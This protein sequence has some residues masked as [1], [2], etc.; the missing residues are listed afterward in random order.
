MRH[1]YPQEVAIYEYAILSAP[2]ILIIPY[3][4][5]KE[6][7]VLVALPI[8]MGILMVFL[9][10]RAIPLLNDNTMRIFAREIQQ[11]LRED[12][13]VGVG[14]VNISQQR[15]GIYLNRQIDEVNVKWKSPEAIPIHRD[16]LVKYI[17]SGENIYLV[18]SK[19][20]Y[21]QLIP[22]ELKT[23]LILIDKRDTWKTRLKRSFDRDIMIE[24][25]HGEKDI[26][27]DVLRHEVY[28]LTNKRL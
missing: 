21:I 2:L 3:T 1:L 4:K 12:D 19:E 20:D 24:I 9:A 22:D 11:N 13:K 27:T 10:G 18:I 8:S 26:L 6:R 15:L 7:D 25:L 16:K 17:T 23:K 5:R 28:L 14:S